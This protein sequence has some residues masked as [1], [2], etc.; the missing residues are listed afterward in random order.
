MSAGKNMSNKLFNKMVKPFLR[1]M[2][3]FLNINLAQSITWFQKNKTLKTSNINCS[4]SSHFK[5]FLY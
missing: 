5:T 4:A 2:N 3:N 1:F